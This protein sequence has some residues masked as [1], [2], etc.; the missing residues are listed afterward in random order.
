MEPTV[1]SVIMSHPLSQTIE[2]ATQNLD[3]ETLQRLEDRIIED[4]LFVQEPGQ[5]APRLEVAPSSELLESFGIEPSAALG[6]P[7]WLGLANEVTHAKRLVRFRLD[8]G[9]RPHLPTLVGEGDSWFLHPLIHDTLD[10]LREHRYNV[11][12]IA[13]A[14][15]TV[16][17]MAYDPNFLDVIREENPIAVLF[18]G[19]G[20]DFLGG[21]RIDDLVH[22][23]DPAKAPAQLVRGEVVAARLAE[24]ISGYES[25]LERIAIEFPG[26]P[27][28]AH[29]YDYVARIDKGP[30]LWPYLQRKN[31]SEARAV[32][33]AG[34]LLDR[35]NRA[36][37][38]LSTRRPNLVAL[39]LLGVVG[40]SP[41][42][43]D[44][45]IHPKRAGFGKVADCFHQAISQVNAGAISALS[46]NRTPA[47]FSGMPSG[48]VLEE[49]SGPY[50]KLS[51]AEIMAALGYR[52]DEVSEGS[53]IPLPEMFNTRFA[54]ESVGL[55]LPND[56]ESVLMRIG[57]DSYRLIVHFEVSSRAYYETKLHRPTKP[58]GSS[59]VTIGI[60]YDLG[61]HNEAEFRTHWSDLLP[62]DA[63]ERLRLCLGKTRAA[64][65]AV[66]PSVADL[67]I[68]YSDAVTVFERASLPKAFASM[69]RHINDD[70]VD[71]LPPK[72]CGALLSLVFNRGASFQ[73]EGDR[74]R[75]M[76]A[77][78]AALHEG[79]FGKVPEQ[80][81]SMKRIWAGD[82]DL[83]GLLIRR[84]K[85]AELFEEGLAELDAATG[86]D[87][88]PTPDLDE[89]SSFVPLAA[90]TRG[91]PAIR[92]DAVAWVRN[93]FNNPDYAHLPAEAQGI[94]F[95]LNAEVLEQAI[96]LGRY[97]PHF[98]SE[99]HLIIAVRG[100][101]IQSGSGSQ[102]R[103]RS[104]LLSE[105][106][107]DHRSHRCVIAVWHRNEGLVSAFRGSTVPNR[108]GVA[109]AHNL[110]N[111]HG[112]ENANMLPTGT[113]ELCVGTHYGSVTIPTVLRLGTGPE[114][115]QALR[116]TTLRTKN[117]G[118]YG[119][120]DFWD[121]CRPADNIHPAFSANTADFSSLGCLTV[122]GAFRNGSHTGLWS[123]FRRTAGFDG[124]SHRGT[125]YNLLLTTGM[126][127]AAI[128]LGAADLRRLAHGSN[129]DEVIRLRT[130]LGLPQGSFFDH[131]VKE[132]LTQRE[133]SVGNGETTGI[134]SARTERVL[135]FGIL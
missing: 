66:L 82:P 60:G 69:N 114:P 76:R 67:S 93:Y 2:T 1:F 38:D 41:E 106:K 105:Q 18:S 74:Y 26:M 10:H 36:I 52:E 96:T 90:L 129:G 20:N 70:V 61:Y 83:R 112:G 62:D 56:R 68:P 24:V 81:R 94:S 9:F 89:E 5:M 104:I 134:Y 34:V 77:I 49:I 45:A 135:G 42:E 40:S 115:A 110:Y 4:G 120:Q 71:A 7:D 97:E 28:I 13:A 6:M 92:P 32:A 58:G 65:E 108:G 63:F 130:A 54:D 107:P 46:L 50:G 78:R 85:E 59:G 43:W 111:G 3:L 95:D 101:A 21:G 33:I 88:D 19:G 80:I 64:A 125:R 22:Q 109:S 12:S 30:W 48:D 116:V 53:D 17:N 128:S 102:S 72:C 126:E 103:S 87:Y 99:G 118:I 123:E 98:T 119:T 37:L 91:L 132:A 25:L 86:N 11:R 23:E 121:N 15:D 127:L 73:K 133:A 39:D 131:S 16:S 117:D 8:K 44:D 29:G 31:Y 14:G 51:D 113:Y 55:S 35:F 124:S 122:P 100:A 79:R 47:S 27:V 75:E 57:P 84:D